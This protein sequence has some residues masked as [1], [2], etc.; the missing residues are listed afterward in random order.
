MADN[1]DREKQEAAQP[2]PAEG[3]TSVENMLRKTDIAEFM[4]TMLHRLK[5]VKGFRS[6]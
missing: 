5:V 4:L 1:D 2:D 3:L 6:I